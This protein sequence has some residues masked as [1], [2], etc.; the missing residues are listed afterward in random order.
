LDEIFERLSERFALL[1]SRGK[2]AQALDGAL[3]WSWGL[4]EPWSK[5]ALSQASLFHGGFSLSAAEGVIRLDEG[6]DAPPMFDVLGDLVDNSLLRKIQ[7]ENGGV[8]YGLLESVR[9]YA[10]NKLLDSSA[11]SL[12]LAKERHASHFSQFGSTEFLASLDRFD[13]NTQREI[14][15]E[16]IDNLVAAI[17]YGTEITAPQCCMAALRTLNMKGPISL[18]VDLAQQVLRMPGL[19]RRDRKLLEIQ[20][21][22]CL[23]ISGR[24][25]EARAVV[26]G[27]FRPDSP[28]QTLV[29]VDDIAPGVASVEAEPEVLD[30]AE[31]QRLME[32]G[33]VAYEGSEANKATDAFKQALEIFRGLGD[34]KSEGLALSKIGNV[35][36]AT[37]K[38]TEAKEH[39]L[40]AIILLRS[41]GDARDEG[42][43]LGRLGNVLQAEGQIEPAIIALT[44]AVAIHR[45]VGN[46]HAE[47]VEIGNLG[48]IFRG[49]GDH[50]RARE[51]FEQSIDIHREVESVVSEGVAHGNL[52]EVLFHLGHHEDSIAAF[53]KAIAICDEGLP[54]AAGVFR[55]SLAMV[56]A[57]QGRLDAALVLI[58]EAEPE[59]EPVR[60]EY[61]KLLC[62]K[63]EI[64]QRSG[65]RAAAEQSLQAARE[66]A[67]DLNLTGASEVAKMIEVLSVLLAASVPPVGL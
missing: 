64:L 13:G 66:I 14:L 2:E 49:Q 63:G 4:L 51:L 25:S 40:K 17:T 65:D 19:S 3:N 30:L 47:G 52:G 44:D 55:G 5:A 9:L 31:G 38:Y 32:L 21:S 61:A 29:S 62:K 33:N 43:V 46:K 10:S 18:G 48:N 37:G 28:R 54:A 41:V 6:E 15:F 59:V 26:G 16:D 42:V 36:Y 58:A 39:Y 57:Q 34:K 27:A 23:R 56:F 12:V 60:E 45:D 8:R 7:T 67:D 24:M 53:E 22:K 1:R 11:S 50:Q 35:E 20:H